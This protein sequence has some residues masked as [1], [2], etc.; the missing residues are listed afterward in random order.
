MKV[1][2]EFGVWIAASFMVVMVVVQALLIYRQLFVAAKTVNVTDA[3]LKRA[4]RTGAITAV[5]PVIAIFI[6]MVGLMS[7]IG[8][9]MAWM[10]LAVIGAAPTE[11]TAAQV[12]AEAVGVKFGG[13]DYDLHAMAASWWT[14]AINGV[15]WLLLVGL[16]AHKLEDVRQKIGGGDIA[17]LGVLSSAAMIGAFGFL[18]GRNIV[19]RGGPLIASV[20]GGIAMVI[21][22]QIAKKVPAIKEYS[23]GLAMLAA[24]AVAAL[25]T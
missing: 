2:N 21:L 12:G 20:A 5:G 16:F 22:L 6:V 9:P 25:L 17:W 10:R 18:S 14:M 8:A 15:G 23:L 7:V 24:M 11:L 3:Q 4:F 19:A 13:A 1:A